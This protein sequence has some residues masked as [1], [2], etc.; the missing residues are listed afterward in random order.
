MKKKKKAEEPKKKYRLIVDE[1]QAQVIQQALDLYSRIGIGQLEE[2]ANH[3]RFY[4]HT[5]LNAPDHYERLELGKKTMDLAK[6]IIFKLPPNASFGIYSDKVPDRY[7]VSW[8]IMRV[9]R[10]QFYND[11]KAENPE[12]DR[13]GG[14]DSYPVDDPSVKDQPL[15]TIEVVDG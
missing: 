7:R 12:E 15:P 6:E 13:M 4:D 11:R 10:H 9:I 8:D 5:S 1:T 14:V 3:L 2:V